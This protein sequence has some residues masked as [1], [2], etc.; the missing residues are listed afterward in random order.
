VKRLP[1]TD[2]EKLFLK[3][4]RQMAKRQEPFTYRRV[5]ELAGWKSTQMAFQ[6]RQALER[7]GRV[8]IG[9]RFALIECPVEVAKAA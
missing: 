3:V 4:L 1:L 2:P 6:T 8:A 5:A 9:K 7:K